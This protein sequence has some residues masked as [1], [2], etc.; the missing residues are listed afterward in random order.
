MQLNKEDTEKAAYI[1]SLV[2]V[3]RVLK[4]GSVRCITGR[5]KTRSTMF[6]RE[7]TLWHYKAVRACSK[8]IIAIQCYSK[9]S[10][11]CG[12]LAAYS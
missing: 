3:K 7:E 12:I 6:T 9:A 10:R 4:E 11:A 5:A 8:Y 1:D 2:V